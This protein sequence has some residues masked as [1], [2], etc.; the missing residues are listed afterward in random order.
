MIARIWH[1]WTTRGNAE[2]YETLLKEEIFV[3]IQNRHIRGF[4]SI[5][6][7]RRDAGEEVEFVTIM[8]FDSLDAVREFA[9]EDYAVAVVPDKARAVLTHFDERSQHYEIRAERSGED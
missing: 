1:G 3:G 9:G 5:Q 6:L 8:L 4:K 7:L 2:I